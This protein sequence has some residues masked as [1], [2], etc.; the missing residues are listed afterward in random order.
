[1]GRVQIVV[2]YEVTV[3]RDANV[4]CKNTWGDVAVA[5]IGGTLRVDCMYGRVDISD[6]AGV[7]TVRAHGELPLKAV[8]LKQG[9]HFDLSGTIAE[10]RG[11]NAQLSVVSSMAVIEL[12][13]LGE[14]AAVDVTNNSGASRSTWAK[15]QNR[16]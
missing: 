15:A 4:D 10:F 6:V 7:A 9:G 5:G 14:T 2:D 3:P 8:G 11:I 12:H 1:M 16:I 13:E